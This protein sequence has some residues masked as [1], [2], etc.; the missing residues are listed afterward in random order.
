MLAVSVVSGVQL[1]SS[2]SGQPT[3]WPVVTG[4]SHVASGGVG[5]AVTER[6]LLGLLPVLTVHG[7]PWST[8][9]APRADVVLHGVLVV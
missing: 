3:S 4:T 7:E 9:S 1:A 6:K 5:G 8:M 2:G